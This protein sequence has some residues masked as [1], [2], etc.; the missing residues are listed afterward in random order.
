MIYNVQKL[1]FTK[2]ASQK[3][4]DCDMSKAQAQ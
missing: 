1:S 4:R 3:I 2:T